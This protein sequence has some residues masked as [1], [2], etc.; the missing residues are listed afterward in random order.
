MRYNGVGLLMFSVIL[1]VE[2][3][4]VTS[5]CLSDGAHKHVYAI[6]M[7][8]NTHLF[9][10]GSIYSCPIYNIRGDTGAVVRPICPNVLDFMPSTLDVILASLRVETS[11]QTEESRP[12]LNYADLD[13]PST[14][15]GIYG[16]LTTNN[17]IEATKVSSIQPKQHH[18]QSSESSSTALI[19]NPLYQM[20]LSD[21]QAIVFRETREIPTNIPNFTQA[22]H[23]FILFRLKRFIE[24][25]VESETYF[26]NFVCYCFAAILNGDFPLLTTLL[27]M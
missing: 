20:A 2:P 25:S 8:E 13:L 6:T 16:H 12:S 22:L 26:D 9:Q 21:D 10:T 23:L 4:S 18:E 15:T 19:S 3:E 24:R 11:T 1:Y 5:V 7:C 27:E 14:S 17:T